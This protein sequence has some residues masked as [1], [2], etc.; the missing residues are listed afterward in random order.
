MIRG[1]RA[2]LVAALAGIIVAATTGPAAADQAR[3]GQW[4]LESMG[5]AE[6]HRITQGEG[7]VVAVLD[8]GVNPNQPDLTGSVLPGID[9]WTPEHKAWVTDNGHGTG[10]AALIA[11]HGHGPGGQDGIL[12]IA[13]KAKILPMGVWPPG[14]RGSRAKDIAV[15]IRY[16]VDHGATVICV[17]GGGDSDPDLREAVKYADSKNV[18]VVGAAGNPPGDPTIVFPAGYPWALGISGT[19]RSGKFAANASVTAAGI[20]FSAPAVDI[21][22]PKA[23]GGYESVRGTSAS[24]ALVAGGVALLRLKYPTLTSEQL[25]NHL[26]ATA[27][28]K[29]KP[30]YDFEYGWGAFDLMAALTTTPRTGPA[31][32]PHASASTSDA[33]VVDDGLS[34]GAKLAITI[35]AVAG[36]L[37]VVGGLIALIVRAIVRRRRRNRGAQGTPEHEVTVGSGRR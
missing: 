31:A 23:G 37:L 11:G 15:S 24:A 7:A 27:V 29:G 22:V 3:S 8:T 25:F 14:T 16:A 26:K 13:P 10:I 20:D 12:G 36:F 35:G 6:A 19:D 30:G 1:L 33:L 18:P 17:A 32:T 28:D 34:F 5:V 2:G 21:Q 9:T 4:Y